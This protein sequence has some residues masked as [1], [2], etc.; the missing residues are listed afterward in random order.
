M[1]YSQIRQAAP[2]LGFSGSFLLVSMAVL[3]IST[4]GFELPK[5][6]MIALLA[7]GCGVALVLRKAPVA[8]VLLGSRQGKWLVLYAV[9]LMLSVLWSVAPV[10]SIL[11]APPRFQGVLVEVACLTVAVYAMFSAREQRGRKVLMSALLVSNVVIVFYGLLQMLQIDP[12][13]D[14]WKSEAFLGRVFSLIGHPNSFG[15]FIVLTIPFVTLKWTVSHER[16]HKMLWGGLLILNGAVLLGTV[17]R[18]ALLGLAV[19]LFLG[20][21]SLHAQLKRHAATVTASQG[22]AISLIVVLCASIGLLF[23]TQRFNVT[24]EQGRSVSSR[25]HIWSSTFRMIADRPIGYGPE[26]MALSSPQYTGKKLYDYESLT[27]TVDR[28]HNHPLHILFTL[29][30]LGLIA[31]VMLMCT[32]VHGAWS[33]R[34]HDE[35]GLLRSAAAGL[36]A[37]LVAMLFSFP[38]NATALVSW[39]LVGMIIGLLSCKQRTLPK[40]ISRVTTCVLVGIATVATVTAV[41]WMQS[42]MIV[43]H[44][45][46]I[47]DSAVKLALYQEAVLLFRA[48]RDVLI[49][50]AEAHLVALEK[51]P[52]NDAVV[53]SAETLIVLLRNATGNRDGFAPLLGA[54][55]A[56]VRGDREEAERLLAD[57]KV[58]LPTSFTFHRT[59][60]HIAELF[61]DG[62]KAEE[63]HMGM[64]GLLPD[65]YF[66]EGSDMRRI[67]QK[68]H[69]WL[70]SL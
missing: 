19:L 45:R 67:L 50:A 61:A 37:F 16:V 44:A 41:Q 33:N 10:M 21:P 43:A 4:I 13:A 8:E 17:S 38:S 2:F 40:W 52:D 49:E 34:H 7:L 3:P 18:S 57:A 48:D 51:E 68:Q 5:M 22:F 54:W 31:Y 12:L 70:L 29:G 26:T 63:H 53:A 58:L 46:V 36:F 39:V 62:V 69:P 9:L 59:G 23:F 64:R 65:G 28:A 1:K 30:P 42:R 32:L 47:T 35:T 25:E 60:V 24:T 55:L 6:L 56:A 66:E 15:H 14:A 20:V 27:T 11:G